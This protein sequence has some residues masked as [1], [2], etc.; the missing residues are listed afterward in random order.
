MYRQRSPDPLA[1]GPAKTRALIYE[2]DQTPEVVAGADWPNPVPLWYLVR[3][4]VGWS[5][6]SRSVSFYCVPFLSLSPFFSSHS[7]LSRYRTTFLSLPRPFPPLSS[8]SSFSLV[9]LSLLKTLCDPRC[10]CSTRISRQ[11]CVDDCPGIIAGKLGECCCR[12]FF[13]SILS[14][15]NLEKIT[16][17]S[18]LYHKTKIKFKLTINK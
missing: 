1:N 7:F 17:T 16:V 2:W 4:I 5:L 6:L 12:D 10:L 8:V 3:P 14:T 9:R 13:F 15:L 18:I 11:L